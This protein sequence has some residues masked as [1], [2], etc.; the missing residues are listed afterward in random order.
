VRW[1]GIQ[2]EL[3]Q[4]Q[5]LA[6]DDRNPEAEDALIAQ[7]ANQAP[8][9][10]ATRAEIATRFPDYQALKEENLPRIDD[11]RSRLEDNEAVINF[12]LGREKSFV[13]LIRRDGTVVAEVS[14]GA[15]DIAA[16]V[17]SLRRGLEIEGRSVA[18]FDLR[19]RASTLFPI[20]WS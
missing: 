2:S 1:L 4:Q 13:Q 16:S 11:V 8:R 18:D 3:A 9:I 14:A 7:I 20:A 5:A 19:Y 17:K 12:L 6:A 15:D 10:A